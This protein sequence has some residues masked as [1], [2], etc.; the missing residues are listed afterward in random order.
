MSSAFEPV[1]SETKSQNLEL[2]DKPSVES[3]T[4]VSSQVEFDVS[5]FDIPSDLSIGGLTKIAL[6]LGNGGLKTLESQVS[7]LLEDRFQSVLTDFQFPDS[8]Y[9]LVKENKGKLFAS[10]QN[11]VVKQVSE[12]QI[13]E[14]PS[15]IDSISETLSTDSIKDKIVG[16]VKEFV[17]E[18]AITL[19]S[20]FSG[21][22][23][24]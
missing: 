13:T 21:G 9:D 10:L 3:E 20:D 15:K 5:D 8:V 1:D 2:A 22:L 24:V 4:G 14:L 19:I 18:S 6:S 16:F 11:D 23:N 17:P 7:K 12:I